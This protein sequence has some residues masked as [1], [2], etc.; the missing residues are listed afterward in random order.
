MVQWLRLHALNAEGP[1]LIPG[2]GTRSHVLELNVLQASTK[3]WCSQINKYCKRNSESPYHFSGPEKN[4]KDIFQYL[5]VSLPFLFALALT[6]EGIWLF[7]HPLPTTHT[8]TPKRSRQPL[9][10]LPRSLSSV[11]GSQAPTLPALSE[12]L[13]LPQGPVGSGTPYPLLSELPA[14]IHIVV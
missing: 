10:P 8:H 7:W 11:F 2:Q 12:V 6:S 13:P 3:T 1:G 4:S 14:I 5:V 9:P